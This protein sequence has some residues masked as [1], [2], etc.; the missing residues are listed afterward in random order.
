MCSNRNITLKVFEFCEHGNTVMELGF[1]VEQRN[2]FY[3][4]RK[5]MEGR[6]TGKISKIIFLSAIIIVKLGLMAKMQ[7]RN[8][9]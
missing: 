1:V 9:I 6:K 7:I 5:R 8:P 3:S 4:L 2:Y